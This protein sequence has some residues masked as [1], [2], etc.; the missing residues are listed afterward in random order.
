MY[1]CNV[2]LP[3]PLFPARAARPNA[4]NAWPQHEG[5]TPFSAPPGKLGVLVPNRFCVLL[6]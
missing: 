2:Q 1:A 5:T 4:M 6:L 3:Q